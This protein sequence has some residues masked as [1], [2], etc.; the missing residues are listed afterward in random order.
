MHLALSRPLAI[1]LTT[2][3]LVAAP[4]AQA[5]AGHDHGG[6]AA[7]RPPDPA[8]PR[9]AATSDLFELVGVVNGRQLTI[10]LDHSA[11]NSPV[12]GATIQLD[13]GGTRIDPKP[14]ADGEF[15]ATMNQPLAPGVVPVTATVTAGQENDLLAGEVEIP[16]AARAAAPQARGWPRFAG[17]AAAGLF[18]FGVL[19]WLERRIVG[20]RAGRAGGAA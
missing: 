20:R 18:V 3:G 12:Q 17:W 4:V 11:D 5:D 7:P 15:E 8:Q 1:A 19:V 6:T 10:Y 16:E 13:L 2:A 9:F 14:R